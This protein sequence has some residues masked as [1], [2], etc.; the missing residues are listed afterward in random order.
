M[1]AMILAA[2]LGTRLQPLTDS[3]PKALLKLNEKPLIYHVI[4]KLKYSDVNKLIINVHHHADQI[5]NYIKDHNYFNMTIEI[6]NEQDLLDTGGGLK[7]ASYFFDDGRPFILHNVD[8][9][10]SINLKHMVE[11]HIDKD[12]MVTLAVKQRKT[13][14]YLLFDA[15]DQLIGWQS[16]ADSDTRIC[17]AYDGDLNELSFLGIHIISPEIFKSFPEKPVFSIID[18]YLNMC[19]ENMAIGAF[20]CNEEDW[21]DLGRQ[22]NFLAAENYMQSLNK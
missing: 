21:F 3:I 22:Q 17:R 2:G 15:K 9:I 11:Y 12:N 8:V 5:I 7:K 19:A 10:S 20:H 13:S 18:A 16:I 1:R 14:R 4:Q 6:S